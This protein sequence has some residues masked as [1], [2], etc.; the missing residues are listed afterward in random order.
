MHFWLQ[1]KWRYMFSG[2]LKAVDQSDHVT[3]LYINSRSCKITLL[4]YKMS[5]SKFGK[6]Y[7]RQSTSV[8]FFL[9][10]ILKKNSKNYRQLKLTGVL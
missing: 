8:N 6:R 5:F 3:Q 9:V 7:K 1:H 10:I 2:L 4:I